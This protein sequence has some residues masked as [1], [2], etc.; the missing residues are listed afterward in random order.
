MLNDSL[1]V[2]AHQK[3]NILEIWKNVLTLKYL[4]VD[5]LTIQSDVRLLEPIT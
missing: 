3:I 4:K 1:F 2:S 5:S